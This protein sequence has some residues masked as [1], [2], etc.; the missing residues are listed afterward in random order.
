[1]AE[2]CNDK[3]CYKHGGVK[4]RGGRLIGT[5][6]STKGRNTAVVERDTTIYLPK[7]KRWA[8]RRSKLSAHNPSCIGAKVG[9]LVTLGETRKLSKTKAWSVLDIVKPA[10]SGE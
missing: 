3:K 1:M 6:V 4:I 8:R 7:Y 5:V 2:E 10:E 9:D